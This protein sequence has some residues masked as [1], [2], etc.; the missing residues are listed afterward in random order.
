MLKTKSKSLPLTLLLLAG[1]CI[2]LGLLCLY[3]CTGVYGFDLFAWYFTQ[4]LVLVLNILPLLAL[5]LVLLA[6][7]DRAW[8]TFFLEATVCLIFSWAQHWKLLARGDPIYAEDLVLIGEATQMAGSYIRIT[9]QVVLSGL[10]VL[11]LTAVL[12]FLARGRIRNR[13]PRL[14]LLVLVPVLSVSVFTH[15][16]DRN[17]SYYAMTVW[18]ELNAW[19]ETNNYISRGG[20]YSFLR[21]IPDALPTPPEGYRE[22][23]AEAMLSAYPS[24][25]IPDSQKVSVVITQLEAFADLSTVTDQITGADPYAEYHA[26]LEESY[27][28][29]LLPN[30]FAGGTIDTERCVLT[31]FSALENFRRPSWSYA[32]YFAEQGYTVEGAHAGYEAF[33]NRR[34]VND[35][36]GIS[37]YRFIEGYYDTFLEGVPYDDVFLPDVTKNVLAALESGPVFSFNVTYQNHGPYSAD[38]AWFSEAYVPRGEIPDSDWFIANNYLWGVQDTGRRMLQMAEQFRAID[39]PVIL[40]FFGDHKPWLGEQSVTYD[41]LGID[42]RGST[43]ESF[44]NY[45]ATDYLIWANDAAKAVLGTD[46]TGTGPDISPCFLMNVLFDRC[47]WEGPGYRKLTDAV[48]AQTPLLHAAGRYLTD[49]V[50]TDTLTP[51]QQELK[52]QMTFVQYY[53]AQDAGGKHP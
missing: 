39:E 7:T 25:D 26:L 3:F 22:A 32:R 48:M 49:G 4:P 43:D 5:A 42:I 45:Y 19:F 27:H 12:F 17:L 50:L 46:F 2:C 21:T 44:F 13:L 52:D 16:Y 6:L 1:A 51:Q 53:L 40:V 11:A 35:R 18:P 28:G 33:Y 34:N 41:A 31:G 15:Y 37:D 38:Y 36:L 23:E 47:G 24:D 10:I 29:R 20:I 30:V 8:L 14:A 9:W